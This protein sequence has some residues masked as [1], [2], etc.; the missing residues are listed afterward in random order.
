M[1]REDI[2]T[3]KFLNALSGRLS[4]R[5]DC[6]CDYICAIGVDDVYT[7]LKNG[8][9]REDDISHKNIIE[10]KPDVKVFP[11]THNRKDEDKQDVVRFI[12]KS[13][14][15]DLI[16]HNDDSSIVIDTEKLTKGLYKYTTT[17][18]GTRRSWK[19]IYKMKEIL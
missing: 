3:Q 9:P 17:L 10:F 4:S 16:L 7:R 6:K 11:N 8:L 14:F 5:R 13:K 12:L 15:P 19:R 2:T 18:L 1:T